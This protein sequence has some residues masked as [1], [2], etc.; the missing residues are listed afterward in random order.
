MANSF[1]LDTFR[2]AIL[3]QKKRV[4]VRVR[5][6][7]RMRRQLSVQALSFRLDLANKDYC[8][9]YSVAAVYPAEILLHRLSIAN[10]QSAS[11]R[12]VGRQESRRAG[13]KCGRSSRLRLQALSWWRLRL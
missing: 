6:V 7:Y 13:T 11:P 10:R 3:L 4:A 9:L 5:T 8:A 12:C 2:Q 1:V